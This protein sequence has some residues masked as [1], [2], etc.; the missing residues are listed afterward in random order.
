MPRRRRTPI[1]AGHE[2]RPTSGTPRAPGARRAPG[3][4]DEPG[5]GCQRPGCRAGTAASTGRDRPAACPGSARRPA[6]GAGRVPGLPGDVVAVGVRPAGRR[7]GFHFDMSCERCGVDADPDRLVGLVHRPGQ[8]ARRASAPGPAWPTDGGHVRGAGAHPAEGAR[9]VEVH[10]VP[11]DHRRSAGRVGLVVDVGAGR[12]PSQ[13]A[14]STANRWGRSGPRSVF[15]P[16]SRPPGA[17]TAPPGW[18]RSPR[19]PGRLSGDEAGRA[20]AAR[21]GPRGA[22]G[23]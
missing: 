13:S 14:S 23:R 8:R 19:R 17:R 7:C 12:V 1:A 6:A 16:P 15:S 4:V 21:P 3:G 5:R 20:G 9:R 18:R 2:L 11:R 10:V 22:E